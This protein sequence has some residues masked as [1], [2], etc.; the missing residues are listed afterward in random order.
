MR[1]VV[2]VCLVVLAAVARAQC[3]GEPTEHVVAPRSTD[4]AIDT[5]PEAH[6][7]EFPALSL[8]RGEL[9]VWFSGSCGQPRN[10]RRLLH[11]AARNGYRAIGLNYANCPSVN[12]TCDP[13]Q[14]GSP[15]CY[16]Q[17]RLERIDGLDHSALVSVTPA[18]GIENRLAKLL[19][20][21]DANYPD[22]GWGQYLDGAAVRWDLAI[23]AGHSQGGGM[24]AMLG[25]IHTVARVAMFSWKDTITPLQ[26]APWLSNAKATPIDR[27]Y[28][29][30][31]QHSAPI[32]EEV[33]WNTL[34]LL[35]TTVN[36]DTT[37]E[38]YANAN[39]LTT[40]VLPQTGSYGN[41]HGSVAT[42][43]NTPLRADGTPVLSEVWRYLLGAMPTTV[44]PV[45]STK[46]VLK[47]GSA[48]SDPNKRDLTMS[49]KTRL[50]PTPNR[51]VPPAPGSDGDPRVHGAVIEVFNG[52]VGV[53]TARLPLP[54]SG[55]KILGTEVRPAGWTF[56]SANSADPIRTVTVKSD[57]I[58]VRGGK[59]LFCYTL[60]EAQ[61]G[62]MAVRLAFGDGAEWCSAAPAKTS[63]NPPVVGKNDMVDR[64]TGAPKTAPAAACLLAPRAPLVNAAFID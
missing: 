61:Q 12:S 41:A 6:Y 11:E 3:V 36:V 7:V 29:F 19:R 28:G 50:D 35:G 14:P 60:N 13:L 23:V 64:F 24:A 17:V 52:A 39:R 10:Q 51:I 25:T 55:W 63:G 46:L 49:A 21:L 62:T 42:D 27:W 20:Y 26:P 4:A 31:H 44:T 5:D 8:V 53:E 32:P 57:T 16:E 2:S 47:D 48:V 9:V 34:G 43:D 1:T 38:P 37:P 56:K 58:M 30:S 18:N 22:E 59:A 45:Q 40:D 15:D 33:A 54:A